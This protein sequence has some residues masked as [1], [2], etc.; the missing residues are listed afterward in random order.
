MPQRDLAINLPIAA[1][2]APRTVNAVNAND[3]LRARAAARWIKNSGG[4]RH[5]TRFV[6]PVANR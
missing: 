4:L 3:S 6:R 2:S 5:G 1:A